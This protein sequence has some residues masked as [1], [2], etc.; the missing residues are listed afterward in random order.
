MRLLVALFASAVFAA[1]PVYHSPRYR[2]ASR[3]AGP[4]DM[5]GDETNCYL[6]GD[7]SGCFLNT[8]NT[9]RVLG[10]VDPDPAVAID[11]VGKA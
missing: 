8:S 4:C 11:I 3:A 2:L 9:T 1:P 10:C 5:S 6:I 7:N